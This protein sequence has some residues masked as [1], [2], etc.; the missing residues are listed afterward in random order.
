MIETID[1]VETITTDKGTYKVHTDCYNQI[2]K[3]AQKELLEE[4]KNGKRN[5]NK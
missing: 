3:E 1:T 4:L 5:K 2:R